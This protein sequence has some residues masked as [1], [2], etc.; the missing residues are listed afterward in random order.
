MKALK[1]TVCGGTGKVKYLI[2]SVEVA[3]SCPICNGLGIIP[4]ELHDLVEV[5]PLQEIERDRI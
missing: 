1:C 3:D 5:R 2:A 4:L